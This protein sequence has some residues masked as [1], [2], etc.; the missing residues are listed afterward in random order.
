MTGP[1]ITVDGLWRCLCP[2]ID[3]VTLNRVLS[4]PYRPRHAS[5]GTANKTSARPRR[6]LHKT[7]RLRHAGEGT[8]DGPGDGPPAVTS[9]EGAGAGRRAKDDTPHTTHSRDKK[10]VVAVDQGATEAWRG[11]FDVVFSADATGRST[12]TKTGKDPLLDVF[13]AEEE[14][15]EEEEEE[16]EGKRKDPPPTVERL[17][18]GLSSAATGA[19][20][21]VEP[22]DA[23]SDAGKTQ[24]NRWPR[25]TNPGVAASPVVE[26]MHT[27]KDPFDE[28]IVDSNSGEKSTSAVTEVESND[29]DDATKF[30][31][32]EQAS[33]P[34][35][36]GL[37]SITSMSYREEDNPDVQE[38]TRRV[39]P[40][41]PNQMFQP[42]GS[43]DDLDAIVQRILNMKPPFKDVPP[44][45]HKEH[46]Y[47]AIRQTRMRGS[48]KFRRIT[49]ALLN[50]LLSLPGITPNPFVYDTIFR[51]HSLPEGSA[52]VVNDLLKEMRQDRIH[53]SAA[54]Y[55]SVLRV[56]AV[57]PDYLMRNDIIREMKERWID[58][59]PKGHRYI[60]IGLLRDEQY[61]LALEK[62]EEMVQQGI[63]V[64]PWVFD[65]FIYVFGKLEFLDDA[66][67]IARHR[68]D[69]GFD[70]TVNIW[71]FLLDVCSKG[72]HHEATTYIWNR[73]VRQGIVNPSDGVSLNILNMAAVYGDA[74]LATEV[75]QYLAERGTRLAR[76]HY[77]ALADA[78]SMQGNIERAIEVYCIM[79]SA[80]AEVNQT[81]VGTL[82]QVLTRDPLLI[83]RAVEAM[84]G[85]RKKYKLPL[86]VYN[87]VL[88]ET[89]K[90]S[91]LSADDAFALALDLYRRIR[92]F[93]PG[94][95]WE[96][97]RNLL[98]RCT[99][100]D[101]AQFLAGEMIAFNIRQN[102]TITELMLKVHVEH[103]GPVHRVKNYFYKV[104]PHLH[105]SYR[106]GSRRWQNIMDLA[107]QLVKRLIAA[108]DPE[109]WRILEICKRNG[110]EEHRI[111]A[112]REEVEAGRLARL[113]NSSPLPTVPAQG[114]SSPRHPLTTDLL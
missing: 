53:W 62:L 52:D 15:E 69:C 104:S 43:R 60:A 20:A 26:E 23:I 78:Y 41:A 54:A 75:I 56:L 61:E 90:S 103:K 37:N 32:L 2:S 102:L 21:G 28:E 94:P 10:P 107:V 47:A 98:W 11:F 101:V 51:A 100:P 91:A 85:L 25:L 45:A 105:S 86:S 22:F 109:A 49:A 65:I 44:E 4:V 33:A 63:E 55:H 82:C 12:Q 111:M 42:M 34:T 97:F 74:D 18:H 48:K 24:E 92:E 9:G 81:S 76:P 67:R 8:G 110:L 106:P 96:T 50:Y 112:L 84:L 73:T 58:I 68:V 113:D 31:G 5:I 29:Q 93:V 71:Y 27:K 108:K 83:S 114:Q 57:H 40:M 19:D 64:D 72:Q 95:N 66:L 77:E 39:E 3:A 16:E 79:Y 6:H 70:V 17:G 35:S 80:G 38:A 99:R 36:V 7:T 88:N 87:A 13:A 1:R 14:A 30:D 59:M 46:I 89:V